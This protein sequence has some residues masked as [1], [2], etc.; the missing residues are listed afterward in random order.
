MAAIDYSYCNEAFVDSLK[1]FLDYTAPHSFD[2]ELKEGLAVRRRWQKSDFE[3]RCIQRWAISE[4]MDSIVNNPHDS[5]EETTY[6]LVLKL[7]SFEVASTNESMR[8]VF[9][10]AAEFI[11]KEVIELF[12]AKEGIYP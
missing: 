3:K 12:R 7:L 5:V 4:L 2:Q 8:N 10:I 1:A 11:E 6:K 9:H